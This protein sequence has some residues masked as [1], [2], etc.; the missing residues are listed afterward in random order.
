MNEFEKG[1]LKYLSLEQLARIQNAKI[2]IAG[3][4]GLGSNCSQMLV[5]SG[6][7]KIKII[8]F[9]VVDYSNL[10]RQFYFNNQVG[11]Y[12]VEVLRENLLG[13]NPDARIENLIITLN[14]TN[15]PNL[16]KD[17]D[18][19]VEAFD[20]IECKKLIIET[21]MSSDKFLIA[22]S[23]LAGWGD[24]NRIHAHKIKDNFYVVG[25]L[26]TGIGPDS[27][28]MA[29][30]V[31]IAAGKQADLVLSFVLGSLKEA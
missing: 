20:R 30:C 22:A 3:A 9:D 10:N 18:V 15:A 29:P 13:I 21:Y 12:K 28:P 17:C 31:Q 16:F 11:R 2:G 24:S 23:G 14:E 5:R 19:V 6:F 8:D 7:K 27:P 25:D 26:V 1:L 4:G